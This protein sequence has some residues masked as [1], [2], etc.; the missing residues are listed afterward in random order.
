MLTTRIALRYLF[1]KKSHHAV[2]IIS[3]I[4]VCG[5]A[6]ATAAIVV[7][8][9]VFNGFTR[10]SQL[11]LSNVDADLK[12]TPLE[13]KFVTGVDSLVNEIASLDGVKSAAAVIEERAML[14]GRHCQQPVVIKAV[15]DD[16]EQVVD[17]GAIII[18]GV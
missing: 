10:L 5:V 3:A 6:V 16:Y 14:V 13:G 4:S 8:L 2:N 17:L 12:L 11:Q 15:G 7:V 1:S 18:D 9:S